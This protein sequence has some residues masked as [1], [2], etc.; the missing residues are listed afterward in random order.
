M[1]L[2]AFIFVM[3]LMGSHRLGIFANSETTI[4]EEAIRLR[5][6]ANSNSNVDQQVKNEIKQEV[7]VYLMER[8]QDVDNKAEAKRIIY[9]HLEDINLIVNQVLQKH[10]LDTTYHVNYGLTHFP[11]KIYQN[12]LYQSGDY[13]AVYI[14][15]GEGKGDNFWCV[16]FPPLC[17]VDVKFNVSEDEITEQEP[18]YSFYFYEKLKAIFKHK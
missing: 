1:L 13:E 15:L 2:I 16:L 3:L 14:V 6:I 10:Q 18:E 17:L 9:Q 11:N 4:P 8:L 5:I 12:K 7:A